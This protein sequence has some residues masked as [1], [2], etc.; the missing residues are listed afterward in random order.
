METTVM[1]ILIFKTDFLIALRIFVALRAVNNFEHSKKCL[2]TWY[3][4][5]T[6][7]TKDMLFNKLLINGSSPE[8]PSFYVLTY[9]QNYMYTY[10]PSQHRS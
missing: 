8:P 1:D 5:G 6:C 3:N 10:T 2:I 4:I 9:I 7:W